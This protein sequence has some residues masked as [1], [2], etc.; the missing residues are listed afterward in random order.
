MAQPLINLLPLIVR[1]NCGPLMAKRA[2]APEQND[3]GGFDEPANYDVML[4]P[5]AVHTVS[6]RDLDQVP[7]ADRTSETIRLYTLERLFVA[8]GG[9]IA[10]RIEYR[11]RMFRVI[12]VEDYAQQGGAYSALAA[13]EETVPAGGDT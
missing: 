3:F 4:N 10:D 5:V 6:G 7:E 11:G 1:E 13:L 2:A 12:R 9:K 8:D